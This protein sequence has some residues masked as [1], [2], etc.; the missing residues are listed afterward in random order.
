MWC[1]WSEDL[2]QRWQ[3]P[4]EDRGWEVLPKARRVAAQALLHRIRCGGYGLVHLAGWGHPLLL[5]AMVF[6]RLRGLAV[7]VET[8]T[9]LMPVQPWQKRVAKRILY[10]LMLATPSVFLPGGTRQKR[11]L[12]H[13]GVKEDRIIVA[14]MTVDV[15][16]ITKYVDAIS[17]DARQ[18]LRRTMGFAADACVFLFVGRLESVKGIAVLLQAFAELAAFRDN[19]RLLIVGDGT[20]GDSVQQAQARLP[21]LRWMGRLEGEALLNAY[22]AAD[23]FVLPS[24]FEP[25]GLVVNEAMA[26]GL[27]VIASKAVGCA[28]DLIVD[29]ETG[30]LIEADASSA[31]VTVMAGLAK[32]VAVRQAMG[33][34]A[35]RRIAPW[36]LEAEAE[37]VI[38]AWRKALAT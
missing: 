13:Y 24:T 9:P 2:S 10:P 29:G 19:V 14:H 26:A 37:A 22:A 34:A 15:A 20:L 8:D 16:A 7:A 6:S 4:L 18:D 27:P 28:D 36:T 17:P 35:R 38:G 32:D 30:V 31:L 3:L 23:V 11:Y 5:L 33:R 12:Q 25:W 21:G 1:S